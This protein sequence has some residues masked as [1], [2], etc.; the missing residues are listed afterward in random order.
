MRRKYLEILLQLY[1]LDS[2]FPK[3]LFELLMFI[4]NIH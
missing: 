2:G 3:I 4:P 1:N